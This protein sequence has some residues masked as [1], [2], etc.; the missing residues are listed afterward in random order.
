MCS[1]I[2]A[3]Q[4]NIETALW[5]WFPPPSQCAAVLLECS[6]PHVSRNACQNKNRISKRSKQ[7]VLSDAFGCVCARMC[8]CARTHAC[9]CVCECV[10]VCVHSVMHACMCMHAAYT[11]ECIKKSTQF[12]HRLRLAYSSSHSSKYVCMCLIQFS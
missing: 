2:I 7:S 11:C 6:H 1:P 10:C 12:N 4:F 9:L 8:V 3:A 5:C